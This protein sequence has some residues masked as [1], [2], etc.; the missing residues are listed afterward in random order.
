MNFTKVSSAENILPHTSNFI[1]F[2]NICMENLETFAGML[3]VFY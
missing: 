1:P 3:F 2:M